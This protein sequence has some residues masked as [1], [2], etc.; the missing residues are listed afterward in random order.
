MDHTFSQDEINSLASQS[1][2]TAGEVTTLI[3]QSDTSQKATN[4]RI[5]IYKLRLLLS[6]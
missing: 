1:G 3:D 4:T 6:S 5:L 2:L